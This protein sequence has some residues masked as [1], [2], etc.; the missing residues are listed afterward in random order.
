M[1]HS[2]SAAPPPDLFGE[3]EALESGKPLE[4]L[5]SVAA[6][7]ATL[8][9]PTGDLSLPW[10]M[11]LASIVDDVNLAVGPDAAELP[12]SEAPCSVE[13]SLRLEVRLLAFLI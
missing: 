9:A 13:V 8:S 12:Q 3:D 6:R 5:V 2:A 11:Q 7:G 1:L 10:A 4:K